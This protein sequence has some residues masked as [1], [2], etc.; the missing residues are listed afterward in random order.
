M[1]LGYGKTKSSEG[2]PEVSLLLDYEDGVY[3]VLNDN[4]DLTFNEFVEINKKFKKI[5]GLR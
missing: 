3:F 4:A 5:S 2:L 1:K